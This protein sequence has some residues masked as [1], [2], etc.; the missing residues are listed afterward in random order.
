[1]IKLEK[2]YYECPF[3]GLKNSCFYDPRSEMPPHY[4]RCTDCHR[5]FGDESKMSF[6]EK[7]E[8]YAEARECQ[9]TVQMPELNDVF[10]AVEDCFRNYRPGTGFLGIV[11]I[12]DGKVEAT[13]HL[14]NSDKTS[15]KLLATYSATSPIC[16]QWL[17]TLCY[18]YLKRAMPHTNFNLADYGISLE[19][20]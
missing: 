8:Y 13:Q 9:R 16:D 14:P 10:F 3:C 7:N 1:M 6:E 20:A 18:Y 15:R 5:H 11:L 2:Y 12:R 4:F 17:C 19:R